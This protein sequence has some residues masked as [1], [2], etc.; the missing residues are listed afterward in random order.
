MPELNFL[1][2]FLAG[3]LGGGHCLGMCGGVVTAFSLNLPAGSRWRHQLAFNIG[4]IAGYT[5][6]G[7]LLGALASFASIGILQG[8]KQVLYVLANL[9]LIL[10]GCYVA[11]WNAWL[12]RLEKLGAPV[13]RHI[14]PRLRTL[15]PVRHLGQSLTVGLL[16]GWMPCGLVYTASLSALAS[17]SPLTGAGVMLAFGLGTLPNLLLIGGAGSWLAGALRRPLW[18]QLCGGLL[19]ALGLWRLLAMLP[20]GILI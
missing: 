3:L 16:W 6:I 18:R 4:R 17:A 5:L 1:A 19:V 14:Q 13:W 9:L 10:M 20:A 12:L 2:L 7:M 11:G 8:L 15:L